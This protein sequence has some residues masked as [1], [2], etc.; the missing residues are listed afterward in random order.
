MEIETLPGMRIKPTTEIISGALTLGSR[1]VQERRDSDCT[2][3]ESL[4]LLTLCFYFRPPKHSFD[5]NLVFVL[6]RVR[7]ASIKSGNQSFSL[8]IRQVKANSIH[9]AALFFIVMA[10]GLFY[11]SRFFSLFPVCRSN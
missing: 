9:Y 8:S 7:K 10:K 5:L 3:L 11:F 4:G 2:K 1:V 6:V